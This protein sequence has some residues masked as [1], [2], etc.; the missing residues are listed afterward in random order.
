MSGRRLRRFA[1]VVVGA[2][3]VASAAAAAPPPH[4]RAFDRPERPTDR[5]PGNARI[6]GG[7]LHHLPAQQE[8]VLASRRVAAYTDGG[9][10]AATLYVA[11]TATQ[12]CLVQTW[13][14]GAGSA[15]TSKSFF[16]SRRLVIT[17]GHLLYGLAADGVESVVVVGAR[18]VPHRVALSPDG[19]FI[20]DCKA[21]NGCVCVVDH[22]EALNASGAVLAREG[23]LPPPCRRT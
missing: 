13:L 14:G 23:A 15:C 5:L 3:A 1:L 16:G 18:G 12:I 6:F 22:G 10:R 19:G 20:Y 2:A 21:W 4:I 11:E 8:R 17:Q 9:G 7:D